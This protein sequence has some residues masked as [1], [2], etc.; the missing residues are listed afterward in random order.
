VTEI[1]NAAIASL[2]F[3]VI[4]RAYRGQALA[5]IY[6]DAGPSTLAAIPPQPKWVVRFR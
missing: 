5:R 4:R 6:F 1:G 3:I 2:V